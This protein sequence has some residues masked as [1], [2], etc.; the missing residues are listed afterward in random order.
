M[1]SSRALET[2]GGRLTAFS[3]LYLSEGIPFGFSAIAL[4]AYLR[5]S[6]VG[7]TEIGLFTASLYLPWSFKW[8][9]GPLVDLVKPQR[10]GPR[11]FW[12]VCSQ[13]MMILTLGVVMV[14][15]PGANLPLLTALIVI[16]NVFA[17]LQD[18]AI[19]ALAV[20][21]L[22]EHERG[23]ANGFMFGASYLG[24]AIGG[25]GALLISAKF[26]FSATYPFVCGMLLLILFFV[27][28]RLNEPRSAMVEAGK[29][30]LHGF[31]D[32]LSALGGRIG[33]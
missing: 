32:V 20:E 23:V 27:T 3:L 9:W 15:D 17:S 7:L 21:V 26:G 11:R 6:G 8:A 33:T 28:L 22:P 1:L 13:I 14:F 29:D 10:F 16:H 12:I 19:D 5:K 4:V 25:S 24:Q 2:K 31:G 30:A 18:V